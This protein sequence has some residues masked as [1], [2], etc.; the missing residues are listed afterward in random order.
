MFR[1]SNS[2]DINVI[3]IIVF[4]M[5]SYLYG[6]ILHEF[7]KIVYDCFSL[8]KINTLI[9]KT[10]NI[11]KAESFFHKLPV[12]STIDVEFNNI[13]T[14]TVSEGSAVN[15]AKMYIKNNAF[16]SII[17]KMKYSSEDRNKID[18]YHSIYGQSRGLMFS[19]IINLIS[20]LVI[21]ALNYSNYISMSIDWLIVT[22]LLAF[23]I[24]MIILFFVRSYRY[25][26]SWIRNVYIQYYVTSKKHRRNKCYHIKTLMSE[27]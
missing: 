18:K 10:I 13:M 3:T 25:L 16:H 23:D 7:G 6:I 2:L 20:I 19:F 5:I 11:D 8:F 4:L 14:Q 9:N 1:K 26:L 12:I 21:V 17:A 27:R 15:A 22:V 24:V